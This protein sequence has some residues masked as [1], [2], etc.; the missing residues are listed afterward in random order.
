MS[1]LQFWKYYI[2]PLEGIGGWGIFLLDSTGYF[3]CVTDYGNYAF[4]WSHHGVSDFREFFTNDSFEYYVDKLYLIGAQ[5]K[6]EFHPD[7]TIAHIKQSIA[8]ARYYEHMDKKTARIEWDLLD[9]ID[10]SMGEISQWEWL[11][12]TD[13][14]DASE[15]FIYDYPPR[16]KGLR[17]KLFPRFTKA[18]KEE[19]ETERQK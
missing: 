6:L 12:K 11:N 19:L 9:E 13:L 15:L 3:S 2:P 5:G 18:L 10:W 14:V 17:D 4:K 7:K 16:V 8:E 1:N